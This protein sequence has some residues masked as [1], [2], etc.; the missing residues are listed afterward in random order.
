MT[1]EA[2]ERRGLTPRTADLN[3]IGPDILPVPDYLLQE[4][5]PDTDQK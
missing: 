2:R 1:V 5:A 3:L 4:L